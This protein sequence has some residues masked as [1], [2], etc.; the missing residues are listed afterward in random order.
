MYVIILFLSIKKISGISGEIDVLQAKKRQAV[1]R[2]PF[3]GKAN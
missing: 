3:K 1:A 2:L